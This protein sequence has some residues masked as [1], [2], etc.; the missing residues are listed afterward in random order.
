[1]SSCKHTHAHLRVH[2]AVMLSVLS[3]SQISGLPVPSICTA[4]HLCYSSHME[5][6]HSPSICALALSSPQII[7][8][9]HLVP[10]CTLFM[11]LF[12][13]HFFLVSLTSL[14][15]TALS[16]TPCLPPSLTHNI[17]LVAGVPAQ[18]VVAL[19]TY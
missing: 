8:N 12:K 17:H 3:A 5:G 10:S 2:K 11:S 15:K 9:R 14:P 7:T 16:L 1:M 4:A 19:K 18:H 13:C 6:R